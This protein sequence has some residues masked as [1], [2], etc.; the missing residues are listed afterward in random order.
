LLPLV[1]EFVPE[2]TKKNPL[3]PLEFYKKLYTQ[4]LT[5]A[6]QLID[7][8]MPAML[9]APQIHPSVDFLGSKP[10]VV[11]Y[12]QLLLAMTRARLVFVSQYQTLPE[13]RTKVA[14]LLQKMLVAIPVNDPTVLACVLDNLSVDQQPLLEALQSQR[15]TPEE[16]A[17][18]SRIQERLG[19]RY[20]QSLQPLLQLSIDYPSR[21]RL[22][23]ADTSAEEVDLKIRDSQTVMV[24]EQWLQ[25]NPTGRCI[26]LLGE[27]RIRSGV[28]YSQLQKITAEILTILQAWD[29]AYFQ[30]SETALE[31][32]QPLPNIEQIYVWKENLFSLLH[33]PPLLKLESYL[34]WSQHQES[35]PG[36]SI[37]NT[38]QE[39]RQK[40]AARLQIHLDS[41]PLPKVFA[42]GDLELLKLIAAENYFS[43]SEASALLQQIEA[44]E[45]YFLP[46]LNLIYLGSLEIYHFGEEIGHSIRMNFTAEQPDQLT[47]SSHGW[48][49]YSA[50]NE[51]AAFLASKMVAPDRQPDRQGIKL[52]QRLAENGAAKLGGNPEDTPTNLL[53]KGHQ[54]GYGLGE[55]LYRKFSP[56]FS[57]EL[58]LE[59]GKEWLQSTLHPLFTKKLLDEEEI[60]NLFNRLYRLAK[61]FNIGPGKIATLHQRIHIVALFYFFLFFIPALIWGDSRALF[62]FPKP[63]YLNLWRDLGLAA[64]LSALVI[65]MTYVLG[66]FVTPFRHLSEE[67]RGFLGD[68]T[69]EESLM[70][71][72]FSSIGE[73][74]LFRGVL[75]AEVGW[76]AAAIFF[77]ALHFVPNRR[78]IAW[79]L[80][81]LVVGLM[82]GWLY[83]FTGNLWA[84]IIAH[85]LINFVNIYLMTRNRLSI[86]G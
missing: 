62:H 31:T 26:I 11:N 49:Y 61:G 84:P 15:I 45:S 43:E 81:A 70:V 8:K 73:E 80:F 24:V 86:S 57:P 7:E 38:L 13:C 34:T 82:L 19:E 18:A 22:L 64:G 32:N 77:A 42:C 54:I 27:Q 30:L 63:F 72:A 37:E 48:L 69:V 1:A 58:Q 79:P 75:Q 44:A 71:A 83:D 21:L 6:N 28:I 67:L 85:F 41:Q 23:A 55:M 2:I 78:F 47:L 9:V 56:W 68:L 76:I 33:I 4:Q 46:R 35:W 14:E 40:I 53:I 36:S 10:T 52:C 66:T 51:A 65:I 74:F 29:E 20:W 5:V 50:V 17:R 12:Q 60:K 16:F 59:G 39:I 25:K 3:Q